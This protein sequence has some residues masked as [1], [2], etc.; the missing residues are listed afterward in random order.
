MLDAFKVL[1]ITENK[2][3]AKSNCS[4]TIDYDDYDSNSLISAP[5]Q[6]Y[7]PGILDCYFPEFDDFAVIG[8]NYGVFLQ[9]KLDSIE[10]DDYITIN[11]EPGD[12]I[13]TQDYI[14]TGMDMRF[15]MRLLNGGISYITDPKII[16]NVLHNSFQD[17]ELI[18]LEVVI[19]NMIR[20]KDD[21]TLLARYKNTDKNN[22]VM[23]VIK[24]AQTDS[25][26]SAMAFRNINK[27][28]ER[29]LVSG[30]ESK[31]NPIEKVLQEDF[32]P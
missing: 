28:I 8:L 2:I 18:H 11:Y 4:I 25:I 20:D 21:P 9:K 30:K 12:L 5:T 10:T 23:G 29:A 27:A 14:K 19:S 7:L 1:E 13:I 3:I 17:S 22:I 16:L 26:L 15:L 24:Q 6:I 31:N 32:T